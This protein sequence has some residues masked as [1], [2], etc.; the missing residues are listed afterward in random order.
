MTTLS[1]I[2]A[3]GTNDAPSSDIT[4]EGGSVVTLSLIGYGKLVLQTKTAAGYT[5]QGEIS[6]FKPGCQ[7]LGPVTFRVVR[8]AAIAACGCSM[9]AE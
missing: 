2:L 3:L 7:L 1:T 8:Q 5:S 9:E 4:V 6:Q